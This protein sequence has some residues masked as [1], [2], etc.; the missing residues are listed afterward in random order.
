M[1]CS[2]DSDCKL[3]LMLCACAGDS[4]G[5]NFSSLGNTLAKSDYVLVVD[6]FDL[7]CAELAYLLLLASLELVVLAHILLL[8]VH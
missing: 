7:F 8:C 5:E 6:V 1:S 2:L 4:A 3:S